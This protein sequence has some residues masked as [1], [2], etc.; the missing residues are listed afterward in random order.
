M[1]W[2]IGCIVELVRGKRVLFVA[3]TLDGLFL[4]GGLSERF[5]A[6]TERLVA[7]YAA[8]GKQLRARTYRRTGLQTR[9]D[10]N[11]SREDGT[12]VP[13][14]SRICEHRILFY[15][16]STSDQHAKKFFAK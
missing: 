11:E 8:R 3:G 6:E 12:G 4:I 5:L 7:A 14:Y 2:V 9:P 1:I 13:S 16:R 15:A 10:E